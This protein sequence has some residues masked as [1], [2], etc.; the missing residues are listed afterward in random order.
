MV[1]AARVMKLGPR[2]AGMEKGV[3]SVDLKFF[4]SA[5][6]CTAQDLVFSPLQ[7]TFLLNLWHFSDSC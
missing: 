7:S 6:S 4:D 5:E 1:L 2:A 3:F